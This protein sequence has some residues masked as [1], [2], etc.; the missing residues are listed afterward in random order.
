MSGGV[1]GGLREEAP[2]PDI[3]SFKETAYFL[4]N[5]Y[6]VLITGQFAFWGRGKVSDGT[7]TTW[8]LIFNILVLLC[9]ILEVG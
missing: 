1:G 5:D 2:Y 7:A 9:P 6:S 8:F 3:R 4:L